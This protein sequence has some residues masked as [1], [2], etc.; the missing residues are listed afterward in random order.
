[1][2][3]LE[4]DPETQ[5]SWQLYTL[6]VTHRAAKHDHTARRLY[7]SGAVLCWGSGI[8]MQFNSEWAGDRNSREKYPILMLGYV[9][10]SFTVLAEMISLHSHPCR[11]ANPRRQ[12]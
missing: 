2:R 12:F 11:F 4:V 1:M 6:E 8:G 10:I 9:V 7:P 3:V 5:P